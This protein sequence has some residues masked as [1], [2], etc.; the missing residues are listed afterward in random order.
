MGVKSV[1]TLEDLPQSLEVTSLEVSKDGVMDSVYFLNDDRVLK[2]FETAGEEAVE[3][4]LQLLTLSAMLPI[5]QQM[6]D[7]FNIC[8]KDAL[9]Y[10][11][12][13]GKSLK[14]AEIG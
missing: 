7:V 6:R 1:I 13:Q 12:C 14:S 3:E 4:E 9:I 5:P 10:R 11:L 2:I 8:G